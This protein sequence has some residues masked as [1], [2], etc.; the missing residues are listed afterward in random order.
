MN[1]DAKKT[2]LRMIPYG[3][4]GLTA[5]DSDGG[6]GELGDTDRV[7]AAAAWGWRQNR[8]W[9]LRDHTGS[10]DLCAHHAGQGAE[11][12]RLHLLPAGRR[13]R[14]QAERPV[15]PKGATGAAIL[16][17]AL[18]AVEC[19]VT[20]VVE[21]GDHHIIVGEVVAAHLDRPPAGRPD[22][23]VLEMKDLGD[24]VFYGG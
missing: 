24:N 21:Q 14:R 18:G 20:A 16:T 7:H 11:E 9:R 15:L 1:A 10:E 17:D 19:K 2:V 6:D 23:A 5:E 22:T 13:S 12:S 8:F 4:Y 3:I